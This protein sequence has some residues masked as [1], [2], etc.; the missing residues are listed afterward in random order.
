MNDEAEL[1][2]GMI[3]GSVNVQ[4]SD[5]AE[6]KAKNLLAFA[7]GDLRVLIS[8]PKIAGYG[9]NLQRCSHMAFV[10]LDDSFEKF[11]QAVR[12]CYRFGQKREV[13]VHI[14]TAENEGQI[15]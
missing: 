8:K 7:H 1:L 4:G 3:K 11:Y 10:G 2:R 6:S 15:L 14:F 5:S 12:R 9:L 13:H